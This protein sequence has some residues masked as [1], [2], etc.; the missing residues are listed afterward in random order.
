MAVSKEKVESLKKKMKTKERE[1]SEAQG[2]LD[3]AKKAAKEEFGTDDPE[4]LQQIKE[5]KEQELENLEEQL[6]ELNQKVE[7]G[8]SKIEDFEDE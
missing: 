7:E 6:E 2:R 8:L 5:E 1:L 3:A 4:E